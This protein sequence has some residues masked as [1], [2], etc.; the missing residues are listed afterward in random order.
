MACSRPS[1]ALE[2]VKTLL[3]VSGKDAKLAADK[4][5]TGLIKLD[6]CMFH[7]KKDDN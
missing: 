2:I 7:L 6:L 5:N 4:V 3:K 1:G